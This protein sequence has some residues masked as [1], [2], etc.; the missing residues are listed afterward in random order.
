MYL[1]KKMEGIFWINVL[2]MCFLRIYL[3]YILKM[4]KNMFLN[5]FCFIFLNNLLIKFV[6]F[7]NNICI[8]MKIY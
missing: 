4:I 7:F 2:S 1:F 5:I 6:F 3:I 8:I